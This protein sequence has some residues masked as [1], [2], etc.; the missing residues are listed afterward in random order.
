MR[1][2]LRRGVLLPPEP[3]VAL[4]GPVHEL[5]PVLEAWRRIPVRRPLRCL[6]PEQAL[7][8]SPP[9]VLALAPSLEQSPQQLLLLEQ[10]EERDPRDTSLTTPL[11]LLERQQERLPPALLPEPWLNYQE[12]PWNRVFSSSVSLGVADLLVAAVLLTLTSPFLLLAA[13]LIWLEDRGPVFYVQQRSG[14]LGRTFQVF[15]L[16][17]MQVAPPD[18]PA[19]W[20][21]PGDQR[22]T[23]VGP[24]C[25]ACALMSVAAAQRAQRRHEPDRPPPRASRIRA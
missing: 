11:R 13:L 8:L 14:W 24:G 22:I 19:V 23:R 9:V 6:T 10:L 2:L 12:L 3:Q 25:G 17:T 16:R 1:G 21:V 4:V 5:H 20:T 7:E 15:K 18:A